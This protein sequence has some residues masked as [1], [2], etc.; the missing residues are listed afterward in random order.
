MRPSGQHRCVVTGAG[1]GLGLEFARQLAVRGDFVVGACRSLDSAGDL[2]AALGVDSMVVELDVTDARSVSAAVTAVGRDLEAIDLLL[3]A[4]GVEDSPASGGPLAALER[5][6]LI[7]VFAVN[8]AGPAV[9]TRA[10][11]AF[12]GRSD[13]AVVVNLTSRLGLLDPPVPPGSI[14]YAIS[15]A[16]L[17]MLTVKLASELDATATVVVAISPGWVRT[18]MG[19]PGAPL[20][21]RE[22]VAGML[23][24]IEGLGPGDSGAIL[25]HDGTDLLAHGAERA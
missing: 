8:V 13:G 5:D 1:R 6:A 19:G 10:F 21:A 11:A 14:G 18:D 25:G 4:A 3:N 23:R 20:S 2:R 15:K 22:S 24:V 7:S 16:G 17:N 9:V 12:L